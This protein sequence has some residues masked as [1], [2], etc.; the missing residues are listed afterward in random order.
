LFDFKRRRVFASF[1]ANGWDGTTYVEPVYRATLDT[2]TSA[3]LPFIPPPLT[4]APILRLYE[5]VKTVFV[6]DGVLVTTAD[7]VPEVP[8]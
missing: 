7:E 3:R 1:D 2:R 4:L 5:G 6:P 8:W